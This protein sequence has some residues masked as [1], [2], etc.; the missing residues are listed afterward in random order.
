MFPFAGSG[1]KVEHKGE[2]VNTY[3]VP[4]LYVWCLIKF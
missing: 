2:S 3:W 1:T 4:H